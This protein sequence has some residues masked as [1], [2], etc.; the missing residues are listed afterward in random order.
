MAIH[1][2]IVGGDLKKMK[3][4]LSHAETVLDEQGICA[5][6]LNCSGSKSRRPS[7]LDP[8]GCRPAFHLDPSSLNKEDVCPETTQ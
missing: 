4:L 5:P 8:A 1:D 2:A 6:L 3:A 7:A